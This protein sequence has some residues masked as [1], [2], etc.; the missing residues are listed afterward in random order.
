MP[1][2]FALKES[3][4][5]CMDIARMLVSSFPDLNNRI[6]CSYVPDELFSQK[7]KKKTVGNKEF[8]GFLGC[9]LLHFCSFAKKMNPA[10]YFILFIFL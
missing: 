7:Y 2:C 3:V 6:I 1:G 10:L 9:I 5:A 8:T 4:P